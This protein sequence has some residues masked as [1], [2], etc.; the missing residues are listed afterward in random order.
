MRTKILSASLAGTLV[1]GLLVPTAAFAQDAFDEEPVNSGFDTTADAGVPRFDAVVQ[2]AGV[3]TASAEQVSGLTNRLVDLEL[4]R[5]TLAERY[6]PGHPSVVAIEKQISHMKDM[7]AELNPE[8]DR[9]RETAA[10]TEGSEAVSL[11]AVQKL[12][13]QLRSEKD[14][15]KKAMVRQQLK[16]IFESRIARD[17]SESE[18]RL[19]VAEAK[20]AELRQQLDERKANKD[21]TAGVLM[22]MIENPSAGAGI[23]ASWMRTILAP[24]RSAGNP[25][26][27]ADTFGGRRAMNADPFADSGGYGRAGSD[28]FRDNSDDPFG[29]RAS[30]SRDPFQ[31][32]EPTRRGSAGSR[33][34][35]GD[36]FGTPPARDPLDGSGDADG[37]SDN[38]FSQPA[39]KSGRRAV[40][41]RAAVQSPFSDQRARLAGRPKPVT[42]ISLKTGNVLVYNG[43]D[44]KAKIL[45][46]DDISLAP[47]DTYTITSTDLQS[48]WLS[49][50]E[51]IKVVI[52]PKSGLRFEAVKAGACQISLYYGDPFGT[53]TPKRFMI[54]VTK[55]SRDAADQAQ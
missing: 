5:R 6:T 20:L 53:P 24:Q 9:K 8:W 31:S 21:K 27:D 11:K 46:R 1:M 10:E 36:A 52:D 7:L 37:Y 44:T 54:N 4:K 22:L 29:G 42:E 34:A 35:F 33:R 51:V 19:A 12:I 23:P 15:K 49:D 55:P 50:P 16:Q 48:I 41:P 14:A 3:Q 26:G 17:L 30:S 38:P 2:K 25:F 45:T 40:D 32:S 47:A 18:Q 13:S 39:Q 28:P 43:V